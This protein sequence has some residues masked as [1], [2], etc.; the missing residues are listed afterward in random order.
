MNDYFPT[1]ILKIL[2]KGNLLESKLIFFFQEESKCISSFLGKVWSQR[3]SH[4]DEDDSKYAPWLLD[5]GL[6]SDVNRSLEEGFG[7][8]LYVRA[9]NFE[10]TYKCQY[11]CPHCWQPAIRLEYSQELTTFEVK[12]AIFRAFI[13][14]LCTDGINFTGG[15]VIGNRDDLFG[16]LEYTNS[17]NI[18]YRINTNSWWATKK[19]LNICNMP[20]STPFDFVVYLKSIGLKM[21]AFSFDE[22]YKENR[23]DISNL[24]ESIKL[25]ESAEANYQIIFTGVQEKNIKTLIVDLQRVCSVPLKHLIPVSME[26][27]DIGR[28][29]DLNNDVYK[30]QSNKCSCNKR[31]FYR[32]VYLHV[33]PEGLVRSCL[34]A[35]GLANLGSLKDRTLTELVNA[36]PYS[37]QNY[38]F[39]SDEIYEEQYN[40]LV[41]PYLSIYKPI[42]HEC[43]THIILA[44]A[45]ERQNASGKSSLKE[46]HKVIAMEMNL[47][48]Q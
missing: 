5:Y 44:K 34:Y 9:I 22:R 2:K 7:S 25:C 10:L 47:L 26:L 21:F 24:I 17:L 33:S 15:E 35:N 1:H 48:H 13:G 38:S 36:F 32:P 37:H 16:I 23:Q 31:G 46:I 42:V 30:W 45:I 12:D 14:G 3:K 6:I 4:F 19:D 39:S 11:S 20:F 43:T 8:L 41:R 28:A 40:E 18:P 29:S 27:V